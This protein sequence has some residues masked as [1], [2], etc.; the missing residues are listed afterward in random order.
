MPKSGNIFNHKGTCDICEADVLFTSKNEWFRD[1]LRC[2]GCNSI[3]R[4]RALMRIIKQYF[5]DLARLSIHESSPSTRGVSA[6]LVRDCPGY[7]SSQYFPD[8]PL[9]Q[10]NQQYNARCEDL[11]HL[12]FENSIFDLFITQD[13]ME[14]VFNPKAVFREI[15][16]VLKVG[17]MH[18]FTV[19]I[20]NKNRSSERRA[21]Q[22]KNGT[23][24]HYLNPQYHQNPVDPDGSL[25]TIDWG[26]DIAALITDCAAMPTIIIQIDDLDAGIR[27]SLID[28]VVSMKV[29]EVWMDMEKL[30]RWSREGKPR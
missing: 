20:V 2:S 3:P 26:Y 19:P 27:A 29:R 7:T 15:S 25:V 21:S 1:N 9:G 5:P 16:R 22:L 23:I 14:H 24:I 18:I 10:I 30:G 17:G 8:T 28:V 11:E 12:T 6:R 13:V 4:E